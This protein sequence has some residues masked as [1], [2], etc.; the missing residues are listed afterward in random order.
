[1]VGPGQKE[2]VVIYIEK[3]FP[4]VSYARACRLIG[5]SRTKKYHI[6]KMK[7]KDKPIIEAIKEAVSKRRY[8]RKKVIAKIKKRNLGLSE[9]RIR[10]V[11]VKYGF[12][13]P[14]KPSKRLR[15]REPNPLTIPLEKNKSWHVD[16]MSDALANG[17]KI[18]TF[19]VVDAFSRV[20]IGI[21]IDF[22]L[23]SVRITRLLDQWMETSG[24]PSS[25]RSDNGPE[26]ISKHFEKWLTSR[27][28]AWEPIRPGQPQENGIVE[29][30]NATYRS[31]I[32]DANILRDI[33]HCRQI[34]QEWIRE[35]NQDRPHE[36]LGNKT[37]VEYAA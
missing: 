35:Y 24:K 13:L 26:F 16:F 23:P 29:R 19:N 21:E 28:I 33:N 17:R 18:R 15:C 34:T 25:I 12:S 27:G 32:L 31:E 4:V 14:T 22:S 30:F 3:Q 6:S 37:P 9:F 10:R 20:C 7:E 1:M 36:S 5:M 2:G 8:G 11:Y